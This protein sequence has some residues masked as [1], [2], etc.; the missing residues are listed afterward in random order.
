MMKTFLTKKQT[1]LLHKW[2]KSKQALAAGFL[3]VALFVG[4]TYK[5]PAQALSD[6]GKKALGIIVGAGL[7]GATA[8]AA[9]GAKWV[10][11]GLFGGGLTGGLIA[12]GATKNS[13]ES[14]NRKKMKLERKMQKTRSA[15]KRARYKNEINQIN[16]KLNGI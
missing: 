12:R 13:Y 1:R 10:P 5:Q 3:I 7:A 8:G 6:R 16:Q 2:A 4:L 11:L 15:Q 14:L 9:G